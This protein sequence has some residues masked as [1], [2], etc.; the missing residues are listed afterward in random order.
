MPPANTESR[1]QSGLFTP[2]PFTYI[3][4]SSSHGGWAV[5]L[6]FGVA[7]GRRDR[8]REAPGGVR[9]G[10]REGIHV[11]S[12][13]PGSRSRRPRQSSTHF[14]Q[15]LYPEGAFSSDLTASAVISVFLSFLLFD[16]SRV[17]VFQRKF[18]VRISILSSFEPVI[19]VFCSAPGRW[20]GQLGE[21]RYYMLTLERKKMFVL[22]T[23]VLPR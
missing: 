23:V 7:L 5:R 11:G 20:I 15:L 8:S 2:P 10:G 4:I 21:T 16:R 14:P 17:G 22:M 1:G 13:E 3:L 6:S 19:V 12:S 18:R 9:H